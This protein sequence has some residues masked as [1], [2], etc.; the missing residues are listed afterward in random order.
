[1]KKINKKFC[2]QL[3]QV[4]PFVNDTKDVRREQLRYAK[5]KMVP[6]EM[7]LSLHSASGFFFGLRGKKH[8][9]FVGKSD[10]IDGHI[11]VTGY[12]GS[13]KTRKIVIPSMYT[14]RSSQVILDV[15]CNLHHYRPS[16]TCHSGKKL[17]LFSP[18]NSSSCRYDPFALMR[19]SG[20]ENVISYA[21]DLAEA[22][23]SCL[24]ER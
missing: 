2:K 20:D 14:W 10:D 4:S 24:S 18:G 15:K 12:P 8:E 16:G 9:Q 21:S 7:K 5:G 6:D 11:L 17:L 19:N 3:T 23:V 1:M 22:M 13:G